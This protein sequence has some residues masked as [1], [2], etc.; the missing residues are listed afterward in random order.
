LAT[1]TGHTDWVTGARLNVNGTRL[2]TWSYDYAYV[3]DVESGELLHRFEHANL[4]SGAI[5]NG[6]ETRL[7]TWGWDGKA[8][9][10]DVS[11]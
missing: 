7:L 8:H 11:G 2:I 5:L 6:D 4:V 9:V 1:L 10:W 3:W